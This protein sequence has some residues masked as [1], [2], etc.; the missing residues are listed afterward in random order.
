[1]SIRE[2]KKVDV[3]KRESE[4][5]VIRKKR[6]RKIKK[7][8]EKKEKIRK[9]EKKNKKEIVSNF[10]CFE[11]L[12]YVGAMTPKINIFFICLFKKK[13]TLIFRKIQLKVIV[14]Y[15]EYGFSVIAMKLVK[16]YTHITCDG[17]EK[18]R[19]NVIVRA[20]CQIAAGLIIDIIKSGPQC[21]EKKAQAESME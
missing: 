19:S 18:E 8:K 14:C 21:S 6:N 20:I 16:T 4:K 3:E 15:F 1:R 5:N 9:E 17:D 2:G 13:L 12:F 10:I 7:K 11:F